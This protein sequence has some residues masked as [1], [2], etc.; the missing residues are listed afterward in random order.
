M[1]LRA[2][3]YLKMR[4]ASRRK[5]DRN[6][7]N[8][9]ALYWY[10]LSLQFRAGDARMPNEEF[11]MLIET[12]LTLSRALL[13]FGFTLEYPLYVEVDDD[14]YFHVWLDDQD[15]IRSSGLYSQEH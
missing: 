4:R 11:V 5:I 3:N 12:S 13:Q 15:Q 8:D 10:F 2:Y 6:L 9:Q 14:T 7:I 1:L